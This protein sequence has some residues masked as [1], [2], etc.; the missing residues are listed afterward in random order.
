MLIWWRRNRASNAAVIS[1]QAIEE[2]G[3]FLGA[4]SGVRLG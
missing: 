1:M 2:P 3:G 4:F